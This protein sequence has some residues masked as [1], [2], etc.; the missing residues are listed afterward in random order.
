MSNLKNFYEKY[1]ILYH[2]FVKDIKKSLN[3]ECKEEQINLSQINKL[4][5]DFRKNDKNY[6]IFKINDINLENL[7]EE[8]EKLIDKYIDTFKKL[9]LQTHEEL[10]KNIKENPKENPLSNI[11][12]NSN[13]DIQNMM[14]VLDDIGFDM[15]SLLGM[16]DKQKKEI[17]DKIKNI[18]NPLSLEGIMECVQVMKPMIE[19]TISSFMKT[20]NVDEEQLSTKLEKKLPDMTK[21]LENLQNNPQI[22]SLMNMVQDK[23]GNMDITKMMSSFG[24]ENKVGNVLGIDDNDK[25]NKIMK[26]FTDYMKHNPNLDDNNK[27]T[28]E[29]N[30]FGNIMDMVKNMQNMVLPKQKKSIEELQK[31]KEQKKL[32]KQRKR[33]LERKKKQDKL[34]DSNSN[35]D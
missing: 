28:Q 9:S 2:L 24:L 3:Q 30:D 19:D 20:N 31:E 4:I 27:N 32:E 22:K 33:L 35:I 14:G 5:L 26:G 29:S 12:E 1:K 21:M 23:D 34:K 17:K 10:T 18:E 25:M 7:N 11:L 13:L 8:Q 16:L 6:L 15:K